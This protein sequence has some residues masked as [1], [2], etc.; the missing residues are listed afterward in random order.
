MWRLYDRL[1]EISQSSIASYIGWTPTGVSVPAIV[2]GVNRFTNTWDAYWDLP[3]GTGD[4]DTIKGQFFS[5][6]ITSM[7]A[8]LPVIAILWGGVHAGVINGGKWHTDSY[9]GLDVWDYVYFHDPDQYSGGADRYRTAGTWTGQCTS[10]VLAGR[11][12]DPGNANFYTYGYNVGIR[13][14]TDWPPAS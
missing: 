5:R 1:S 7:D 14:R 10:Q 6:Q 4:P 13:G 12:R 2:M 8:K 9:T 3:G 11:V